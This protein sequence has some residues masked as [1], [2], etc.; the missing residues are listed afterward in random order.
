[1]AG[2]QNLAAR[3]SKTVDERF[4]RESQAMMAL[5]NDYKF[6]GVRTV[7]VYSL[8][9]VPMVDYQRSG[10]NRY[11][12]PK[13]LSRNVQELTVTKDRAFTFIIDRGDKIQS[14][15]VS[16]SGKALA[17]EIRE[18]CVPEFDNYVFKKLAAEATARGNFSSTAITKTNAYEL[19]LNA[20]ENLGNH[21]VPDRGRVCFCTYKFANLLKQDSAFMRYSDAAQ[22]MLEKGVIGEVDGTKI[23]KVPSSRLPAGA[24]FLLVHPSA[25][26]A[27]KQLESY[28]IH[29]DPPGISGSLVEGRITY[30]CFILNEKADAIFYHGSQAVL[31]LLNVTSAASD[32]GKSTIMVEP[33]ALE[34]AKRYYAC[35]SAASGLP[36]VTYG[37]AITANAWTELSA[38]GLEISPAS[39]DTVLRVVETDADGKPIAW[40][41]AV[42]YTG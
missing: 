10:T 7:K 16:D 41:D 29:D 8:P 9:T 27:P 32:T 39:G 24:A 35:K 20:Q 11:G 25:A 26:T 37:T 6:T 28:R 19:F 3:Y 23:V 13:D 21:N 5:S 15:M 12:N 34:G 36:A 33:A 18:V 1:M 14:E 31:K 42:L 30:D 38:N 4:Y 17:R 2:G 22:E 40:G